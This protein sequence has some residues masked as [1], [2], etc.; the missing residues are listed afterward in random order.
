MEKLID[1]KILTGK[2]PRAWKEPAYR[3]VGDPAD[4]AQFEATRMDL[5]VDEMDT[6]LGC[7]TER[8]SLVQNRDLICALDMAC[9]SAGMELAP[10]SAKYQSGRS[11]YKFNLPGSEFRVTGDPSPQVGQIIVRNDYRGSGGLGILAGWFTMVCSNGMVVGETAH[12][13]L[14]RHVGDIDLYGFVQAGVHGIAD[15]LEAE[16]IMIETLSRSR[17]PMP[18]TLDP[19]TRQ[20]YR[21]LVAKGSKNPV[22][23]ILADTADRY[24][25]YL[26]EA[27]RQNRLTLGDSAW[28]L[29]SAITQTSTHRMPGWTA[30]EWATRQ[31][32]RVK[33]AVA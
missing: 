25:K 33:E 26:R 23:A 18:S 10:V 22:D 13:N 3:E 29:V 2:A 24:Q 11:E 30:D 20:E 28:A 31:I 16:R 14:R 1:H 7:V 5:I 21:E 32:N 9:D 4:N 6:V 8:Y 19:R 12:K 17:I 27:V 15:K